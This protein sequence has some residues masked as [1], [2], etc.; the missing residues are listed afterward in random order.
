MEEKL[1]FRM[2]QLAPAS[3]T[4]LTVATLCV[5]IP[6]EVFVRKVGGIWQLQT[7]CLS[8]LR[9]VDVLLFLSFKLSSFTATLPAAMNFHICF[10]DGLR[11]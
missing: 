3:L 7:L 1:E 9:R 6:Q 10:A 4:D 8:V 2:L 11:W 5:V